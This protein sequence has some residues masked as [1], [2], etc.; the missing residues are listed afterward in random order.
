MPGSVLRY[1][2]GKTMIKYE[3]L[4]ELFNGVRI[5][6]DQVVVHIDAWHVFNRFFRQQE[7]VFFTSAPEDVLVKDIVIGFIN[8][9][10]HYRKYIAAKLHK[11][12]VFLIYFNPG[13]SAYHMQ[14][15]KDYKANIVSKIFN[16]SHKDYIIVNDVLV[17]AMKMLM[18]MVTRIEKV[19]WIHNFGI[20][21]PSAICYTMNTPAYRDS[22]HILFSREEQLAELISKNCI[23]LLQRKSGTHELLTTNNFTENIL[24]KYTKKGVT[25][26]LTPK[27]LKFYFALNGCSDTGENRLTFGFPYSTMTRLDTLYE[28]EVI[29]DDSSIQNVIEELCILEKPYS[30]FA[31]KLKKNEE[32]VINRYKM[33]DLWL[34]ARSISKTAVG[35]MFHTHFDLYDQEALEKL[36]EYLIAIDETNDII[37][38][39]NLNM[40]KAMKWN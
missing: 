15:D 39:E 1:T 4:D 8:I 29:N 20:D 28:S 24:H 30:A 17:K 3:A 5:E 19:Y 14:Y 38:L 11:D 40:T 25:K 23:Q 27:S 2:L 9:I 13:R 22:F 6:P 26:H 21:T 12:N 36:N 34:A 33:Y 18:D 35:H 37:I 32:Y 7:L 31:K 16:T 10:G